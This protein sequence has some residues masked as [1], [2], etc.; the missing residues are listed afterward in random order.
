MQARVTLPAVIAMTAAT[1]TIAAALS[2]FRPALANLK[3]SAAGSVNE[4]CVTISP[5]FTP[6]D[7][8][9]STGSIRVVDPSEIVA[10]A[11][12][13]IKQAAASP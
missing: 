3:F 10:L 13:A 2:A 7:T 9:F 6:D 4:I 1:V 11:S 12:S 5:A 8:S